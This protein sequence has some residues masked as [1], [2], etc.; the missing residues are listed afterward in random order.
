MTSE[1]RLVPNVSSAFGA[2]LRRRRTER[3]LSQLELSHA[4]RISTRHLSFLEA[5]RARPSREMILH[6][7]DGL[8]LSF[9]AQNELLHAGGF[10]PVYPASPLE[11]AA[12]APFLEALRETMRRHSPNPALICDRRWRLIEAN[13]SALHLF[14]HLQSGGQE[15][16]LIRLL[17]DTPEAAEHVA[18]LP[19]VLA[20]FS[21]RI[22]LELLGAGGD[23]ELEDLARRLESAL[24]RHPRP[25]TSL[26]SPLTP[27]I[28]NTPSGKLSLMSLIAHFGTGEDVTVRDLRLELFFPA[29]DATREAFLAFPSETPSQ[30]TL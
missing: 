24:K 4:C 18:N 28:L 14:G 11:S 23:K 9:A 12:L 13:A 25:H 10:A 17:T 29:D 8:F 21:A 20:E 16:N 5:G 26:R 6:L 19:D 7:A 15:T 1:S 27:L 30:P 3:G 22:R 2:L